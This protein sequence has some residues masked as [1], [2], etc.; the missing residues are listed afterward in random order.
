MTWVQNFLITL[1]MVCPC[2]LRHMNQ[3]KA[4]DWGIKPPCTAR[5][6]HSPKQNPGYIDFTGC[7]LDVVSSHVSASLSYPIKIEYSLILTIT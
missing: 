5:R 3:Q 1:Q 2:P 7:M 4:T 6:R